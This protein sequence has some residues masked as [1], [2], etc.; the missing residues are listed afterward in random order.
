MKFDLTLRKLNNTKIASQYD[1]FIVGE[2]LSPKEYECLLAIAICFTN[3]TDVLVQQLGYRIIVEFC[4]QKNSYTSL[5]EISINKGLYPVSN[6]IERHCVSEEQRNFFTEW[7][8]AFLRQYADEDIYQSEQQHELVKFFTSKAAKTISVIAPT[9]YGKSELILAAVKEYAGKKICILTST[10][11]LLTQTKK[12]V[13]TV[14]RGIFP[15]IIVH[16]EMYNKNADS[17][18]AVLTQERLLR[19]FKKDP[20]LAFDCIVVDEAHELLEN[21]ARSHTLANVIIVAQNRNPDVAFKFLT[22][23][24]T[25]GKNLKVRYTTYD[26][27]S[28]K[29]SEYIKTEK[30]FIYDLRNHQGLQLYDQF[31]NQYLPIHTEGDFE[32]EEE[33]VKAYGGRKNI[34]YLNKPTDIEKFALALKD[35]LPDVESELIS[36]A[37]ENISEY[38]QPQYNLLACLRKGIIYHHGSVPDAIRIYIED[39]YKKD[40]AIKYVITS[41]TLLSGINLPAERM[42]IL[43]NR[44]GRSN[45]SHDAF[46]NLVGRICRFSEIFDD[47]SGSLQR[48]EPHIYI[49]FGQYFAQSSNCQKF[50]QSVARV[51]TKHTDELK[52]VLL[53]ETKIDSSNDADLRQAS[54]FIENYETGIIENYHERY[55]Q[56]TIGKACIMNGISEIDV[57]TNEHDMQAKADRYAEENLKIND[58]DQL[59][60]FIYELFIRYLPEGK[61]E[62]LKRLEHPEARKFYAMMF[63]WRAENKSY[64]EMIGLF[65]GYWWRLFQTNRD[66]IIYVGKWGDINRL[67]STAPHY[68]RLRDKNR[69][70]VVNL[71]IVRIKEE[72]DFIDN[73]LIKYVEVLHDLGF[74]EDTF[75]SKIKYGTDD[76]RTICLLKNGLSLSSA[77][78]L[79]RKYLAHLTIDI[80]ESTVLFDSTLIADMKA[81]QE[82]D[83]LIC[84]VQSCM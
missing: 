12:R 56:T 50:L 61:S 69:T 28:F 74:L 55:T 1:R 33:F 15:K 18:L 36:T 9:S 14:S 71:A 22:P 51:E 60:N 80:R 73:V 6:F 66:C 31:L 83:I 27:E 29:V 43:D 24:L 72:Q 52:N 4:N 32:F 40:P 53:D 26:I 7:N 20:H 65:V 11:A 42:F 5:Y 47:E 46:K 77:T 41:S 64:S 76:E 82:N 48:L 81:N 63:G 70:Q 39:L 59:L 8:S 23:F 21:N 38:L 13:Q 25:D 16:P 84:E 78:L 19:I 58:P 30:Y 54:E 37:C 44:R 62:S 49:V 67:G 3:A 45:L 17:C 75:Y 35:V 57:F 10:K 34:I 2:E 79:L 68:T